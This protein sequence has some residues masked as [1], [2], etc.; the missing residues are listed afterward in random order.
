MDFLMGCSFILKIKNMDTPL[1]T[2]HRNFGHVPLQRPKIFN[3]KTKAQHVLHPVN[4][5]VILTQ[6]FESY[7]FFFSK[8]K[9]ALRENS[10]LRRNYLPCH[11]FDEE[12]A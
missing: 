11:F 10:I 1:H 7:Q 9:N 3:R 6:S 5:C 4:T 8:E 12:H 2:P